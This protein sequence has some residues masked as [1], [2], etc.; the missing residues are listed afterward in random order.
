MA[1]SERVLLEAAA[2]QASA[3]LERARLDAK[4]RGVQLEAETNQLRAAMFSSV[5]H[6]LRT[7]LAS[8]MAGVTSLLD[9]SAVHDAAQQRELLLTISEETYRLNRLV[10]NIMDLARIRAGALTPA[11]QA[12][13]LDEVVEA[14]LRRLRVDRSGHAV[15]LD[16]PADLPEVMVDP[17]QMDQVFTNLI[18]NAVRHAPD[19]SEI[20]VAFDIAGTMVRA[21]V[22]DRGPGI[23]PEERDRVFEAFYRGGVSPERPGSGL[24][25]AIVRAIVL[26][27]GGRVWIE[28][29][30]GGGTAVVLE[31]P[32]EEPS[33][34]GGAP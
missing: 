17:M 22:T 3:A 24:G 10:G 1:R 18:E 2:K 31:V 26:A 9:E 32:I 12:T 13:G 8:I 30:D 15:H 16:L 27:H 5:T 4:V 25:L 11:R 14:V 29:P 20:D 33:D 34:E 21:R 19:G 28:E 7:P 23:P 6:D